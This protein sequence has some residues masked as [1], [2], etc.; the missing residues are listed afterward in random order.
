ML[1]VSWTAMTH[2]MKFR[3]T[4]NRQL[5]L[6]CFWT[7]HKQDLAGPLDCRPS[8]A[9]GPFSRHRTADIL[10]HMKRVSRAFR[11]GLLVGFLRI[12]CNGLCIEQ[13]FRTE[14]HDHTCLIGCLTLSLSQAV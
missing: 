10:L 9:L 8:K 5:P 4:K 1:S 12:L 14:E 6:G 13:R 2:L 11:P 7:L 3:K